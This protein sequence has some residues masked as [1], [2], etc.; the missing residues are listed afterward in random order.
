MDLVPK[1]IILG[2][3]IFA[4]VCIVLVVYLIVRRIRI[5]KN[6]NFEDRSN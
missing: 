2:Y 1:L 5:K 6:E 4:V 3:G